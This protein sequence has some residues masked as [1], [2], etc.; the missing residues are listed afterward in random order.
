MM[1]L[2]FYDICAGVQIANCQVAGICFMFGKV[3]LE[4]IFSNKIVHNVGD[5]TLLK[6]N[7]TTFALLIHK[8]TINAVLIH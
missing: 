8:L 7:L 5:S 4:M 2:G 1:K 6:Y 3:R